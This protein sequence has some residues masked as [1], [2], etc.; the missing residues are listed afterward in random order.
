MET[1]IWRSILFF[2]LLILGISLFALLFFP[3]H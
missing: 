2:I 3:G 1:S